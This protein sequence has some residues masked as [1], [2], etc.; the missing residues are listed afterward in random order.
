MLCRWLYYSTPGRHEVQAEE[1]WSQVKGMKEF[2]QHLLISPLR[3]CLVQRFPRT[4]HIITLNRN[5]ID[6]VS[7]TPIG[8]E[9]EPLMHSH[10]GIASRE[11]STQDFFCPSWALSAAVSSLHL[12]LRLTRPA[13]L[14][15]HQQPIALDV[16]VS[17]G[18]GS[19]PLPAL[20]FPSPASAGG[21]STTLARAF[22]LRSALP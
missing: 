21:P 6:T 3:S 14:S 4:Y 7:S 19:P 13:R 18:P 12:L 9:A 1:E 16:Q 2:P 11:T 20:T 22:C 15:Y 10:T 17:A 8:E 5:S